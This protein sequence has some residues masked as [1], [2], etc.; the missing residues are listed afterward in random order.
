MSDFDWKAANLVALN[1][2]IILTLALLSANM[3]QT[4]DNT[5]RIEKIHN[6]TV[7]D[8]KVYY[9]SSKINSSKYS[10]LTFDEAVNKYDVKVERDWSDRDE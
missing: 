3:A 10:N 4:Q 8:E 2:M 1:I 6:P 5:D 7:N 9:N